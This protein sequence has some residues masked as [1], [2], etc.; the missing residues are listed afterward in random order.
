MSANTTYKLDG[1]GRLHQRVAIVTGSSSGLG[2]AIALAL[3]REGAYVVCSDRV[4]NARQDGFEEDKH[5]N[6]DEVITNNGGKACFQKCDLMIVSEIVALIAS[7][8]KVSPIFST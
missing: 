3:A 7:A 6:T 8:V 2:R 5:I 1:T 4:P